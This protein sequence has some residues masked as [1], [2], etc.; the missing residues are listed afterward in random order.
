DHPIERMCAVTGVA[1]AGAEMLGLVV[2]PYLDHDTR[3]AY[4]QL[5][6]DLHLGLDRETLRALASRSISDAQIAAWMGTGGLFETL[7]LIEV[8]RCASGRELIVAPARLLGL[9]DGCLVSDPRLGDLVEW[10]APSSRDADGVLAR[11]ARRG[12]VELMR[13]VVRS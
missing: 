4:A 6:R 8:I 3:T 12:V 1:T 11:D 5:Q 2:A 9:F 7:G 10:R 13:D